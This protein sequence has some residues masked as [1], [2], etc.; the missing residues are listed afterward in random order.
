VDHPL[1]LAYAIVLLDA[2]VYLLKMPPGSRA[3][4]ALRLVLFAGLTAVLF[5]SGLSPFSPAPFVD[6]PAE[7]AAGQVVEVIWW[8]TGARLLSISLDELLVPQAWRKQRLFQ[9]VFGALAFL[10]AVVASVAFVLA[11]PVR[12]LV[13]TSGALAIVLGL[14]IQSTLSDVFAGIVLNTTEPYHVGD[15]V[16]FD[17]VE[18]KV[19]E[20]NW[21]ATHLLNARGNVVVVP[22]AVAAK[23]KITNS[24]RPPTVHG[25]ALTLDI[26]PEYRPKRVLDALERALTGCAA[27]LATPASS[28]HVKSTDINAIRYEVVG[29]ISEMGEKTAV[30]N[31]LL[32][33]CFR[34]LS[35]A[36]VLLRPLGPNA[37]ASRVVVPGTVDAVDVEEADADK[38]GL[39]RQVDMFRDVSRNA[40]MVLT[41]H[42]TRVD[43]PSGEAILTPDTV[44]DSL[45]IVH[46]GVL[47]VAVEENGIPREVARFGP[48]DTF[49]EAGLLA[50]SAAGAYVSALTPT[51]LYTLHT[52]HLSPFLQT[53]P[54][55][56]AQLCTLLSRRQDAIGRITKPVAVSDTSAHSAF[57]WLMEKVQHLHTPLG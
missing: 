54:D 3:R 35:A 40:L 21:R 55:V 29:Y 51:I 6:V 34:H 46:S 13:A 8:L 38:L 43:V 53:H 23:A 49:G 26:S 32:D 33:L 57:Q 50:G 4:L 42:L 37:G 45:T 56:A 36:G 2:L 10:G 30:T 47:S 11:L 31:A 52:T 22:N 25:V 39:L 12:G 5:G 27:I 15:W 44:T 14:A 18:G 9:D 1:L 24:N 48:G 17:D 20:M 19:L 28:A 16:A 41:S 7:H